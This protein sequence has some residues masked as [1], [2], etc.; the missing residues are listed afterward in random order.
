[1]QASSRSVDRAS[2]EI[3]ALK[4][5][6]GKKKDFVSLSSNFHSLVGVAD[7]AVVAAADVVV[8]DVD[9]D[10]VNGWDVVA[11]VV[12]AVVVDGDVAAADVLC[13][14]VPVL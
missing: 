13:I 1:M 5:E 14:L 6:I 12:V 8:A 9:V 10:V 3:A 7:V 11:D 2:K 4:F